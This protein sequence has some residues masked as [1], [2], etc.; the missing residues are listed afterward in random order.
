[1]NF[2]STKGVTRYGAI[3]CLI[4]L[5]PPFALAQDSTPNSFWDLETKYIF[6]FTDGSHIGPATAQGALVAE[7]E[8]Q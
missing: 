3:S 6:R 7:L 1:M 5:F 2:F 8:R 4:V